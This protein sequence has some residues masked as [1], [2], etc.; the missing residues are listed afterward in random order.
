MRDQPWLKFEEDLVNI[1]NPRPACQ[2]GRLKSWINFD[3][4]NQLSSYSLRVLAIISS[5]Q[6][7]LRLLFNFSRL[8]FNIIMQQRN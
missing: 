2:Q 7:S 3:N 5:I 8:S 1:I 6:D 4:T